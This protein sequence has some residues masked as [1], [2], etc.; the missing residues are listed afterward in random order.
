MNEWDFTAKVFRDIQDYGRAVFSIDLENTTNVGYFSFR[1]I[2][3]DNEDINYNIDSD[4]A[5]AVFNELLNKH[6][7]VYNF[8]YT[9]N[10][11]SFERR[12]IE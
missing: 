2:L 10:Q 3:I 12:S 4:E 5:F 8:D 11:V 7:L 9:N 6:S 1:G